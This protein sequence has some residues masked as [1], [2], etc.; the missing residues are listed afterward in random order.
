MRVSICAIACAVACGGASPPPAAPETPTDDSVVEVVDP[1]T[2]DEPSAA[3]PAPE[4]EETAVMDMVKLDELLRDEAPDLKGGN[5][6]WE[7][8]R[9]GVPVICLADPGADRMRLF[10]P[11]IEVSDMTDEQR[12]DV[13]DAN[14]HTALDARYATAKGMLFAAYLHP[15]STLTEADLRSAVDQVAVLARTFGT[16]Y[17]SGLLEFGPAQ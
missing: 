10:A 6:Q 4:P 9:H 14:F 5:G 2:K 16:S 1:P 13:L 8:V 3:A 7:L 17:S 15:L 12:Q 11:V